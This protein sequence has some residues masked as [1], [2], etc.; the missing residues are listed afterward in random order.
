MRRRLTYTAVY[1]YIPTGWASRNKCCK[2]G[3]YL[4]TSIPL[5]IDSLSTILSE[6]QLPLPKLILS[7]EKEDFYMYWRKIDIRIKKNNI[8]INY[9]KSIANNL[10]VY[11]YIFIVMRINIIMTITLFHICIM[12]DIYIC[13]IQFYFSIQYIY[14]DI[15]SNEEQSENQCIEYIQ[16]YGK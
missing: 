9:R 5:E 11:L 7:L 10:F 6:I 14:I 3:C 2:H 12:Y 8:R 15:N 16:R 4:S 13:C 1:T